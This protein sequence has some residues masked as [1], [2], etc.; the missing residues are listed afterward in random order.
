M[1][2]RCKDTDDINHNWTI[3]K[4]A[5]MPNDKSKKYLNAGKKFGWAKSKVAQR[6][7]LVCV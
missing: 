2:P 4:S 6:G 1:I 5:T 3:I 7:S